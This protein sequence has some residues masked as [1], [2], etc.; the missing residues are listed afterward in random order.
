MS[1][2]NV[3]FDLLTTATKI[4]PL[5]RWGKADF[6][7]QVE[8]GTSVL[9]E[10]TA[11]RVNRGETP[12]WDTLSGTTS[13]TSADVRVPLTALTPANGLANIVNQPIE[14]IRITATGTC[15][16]RVIQTG[17]R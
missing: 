13:V 16:G 14:A 7:V 6:T 10:G 11:A 4:I 2:L 5:D 8:S 15:V 1:A 9:V 3:A 12:V 17:A